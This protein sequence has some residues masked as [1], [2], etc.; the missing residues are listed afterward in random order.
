MSYNS[1][2]SANKLTSAN[3][4]VQQVSRGAPRTQGVVTKVQETSVQP[5]QTV[6]KKTTL[7]DGTEMVVIQKRTV[8]TTTRTSAPKE[9]TTTK[10]TGKAYGNTVSNIAR[11]VLG[12]KG[13]TKPTTQT[14]QVITRA[15]PTGTSTVVK[16]SSKTPQKKKV[17]NQGPATVRTKAVNRYDNGYDNVLIT[18]I[19]NTTDP[20]VDFH[21]IDPLDDSF[22]NNP[23][24]D[25][26]KLRATK[27]LRDPK[28]GVTSFSSSVDNWRPKPKKKGI[29]NS[30][31]YEHYGGLKTTS[32]TLKGYSS[33]QKVYT[34]A[35]TSVN[36]TSGRSSSKK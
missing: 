2:Y 4:R 26:R 34:K 27:N 17:Y 28:Y 35:S 30:T 20:D 10:T 33:P 11:G 32:R 3:R 18:H 24:M 16:R 12:K 14:K 36:R 22:V 13:I 5:T 23:P 1:R 7:S 29:Y 8:T 31:V 15:Q 25:L 19:I 21:I 9:T 6:E